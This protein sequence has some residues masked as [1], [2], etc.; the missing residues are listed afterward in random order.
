[1]R[2]AVNTRFLLS[3]HIE[4]IGR[5]TLETVK[6]IVLAHP[7]DEFIFFF[8]R[9][10]SPEFVFA[11]NVQPVVLFP[12]ARHPFLFVAWFEIAVANALKKYNCD[13]FFSPDGFL[14]LRTAVPTAIVSHDLAYLHRPDDVGSLMKRYYQ[15][16]S[17][18]F[19]A[20]AAHIFA[21]S[22]FTAHDILEQYPTISNTKIS[23]TY[24]AC[25][26]TAY[27][28]LTETEKIAIRHEFSDGKPYFL[29]VGS[30]HPRKNLLNLLKAFEQFKSENTESNLLLVIAGR[31]AWKAGEMQEFYTK[32]AHRESVKFLDFVPQTNLPSLISAAF[33]LCYVSLFEGFGIPILEAMHCETPV[34]TSNISSMPEVAD[35]AALLVDPYNSAAIADGLQQLY[36]SETLRLRLIEKGKKRRTDFSWDVT[37]AFIWDVLVKIQ[38]N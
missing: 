25:D 29:Y 38:K 15:Y 24:N 37:A 7:T 22:A 1:M 5:F 17:P 14:S 21:V 3:P 18:R 13:V 28:P 4:G 31:I 36:Q 10:F 2:I 27:S 32:M 12:P 16:F 20:K 33:A 34:L 26:E 19:H 6:R 9:P 8:D 23:I 11:Q 35:G 30:V